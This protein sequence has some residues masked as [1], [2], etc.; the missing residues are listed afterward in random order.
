MTLA[1]LV[2]SSALFVSSYMAV[3]TCCSCHLLHSPRPCR[4]DDIWLHCGL[5]QGSCHAHLQDRP[6]YSKELPSWGQAACSYNM[7]RAHVQHAD[8]QQASTA[9]KLRCCRVE[10]GLSVRLSLYM[11]HSY[12]H[13][14][15][16]AW[17]SR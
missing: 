7:H 12:S 1:M 13:S 17:R 4:W 2:A 3:D 11:H 10:E 9:C 14:S 5:L 8:K 16:R 6:L 15:S